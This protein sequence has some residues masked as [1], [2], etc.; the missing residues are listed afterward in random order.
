MTK[1]PPGG[2]VELVVNSVLAGTAT[3]DST[4][5]AT[6]ALTAEARGGKTE[7]DAYVF[8]EYCD[9]L[10]RVILIE[11]GMQGL[12]G[13]QCPRREVPGAFVVRQITTLVVN[14][15]ETAPSVLVRQGKAPAAWLTDEVDR[16][17]SRKAVNSPSRGLYGFGAGGIASLSGVRAVVVRR[18]RVRRRHQTGGV[19]RGRHVL[20]EA[21]LRDRS[22][23]AE[24]FATSG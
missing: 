5:T 2:T 7:A 23:L 20:A 15:S 6:F 19:L 4:G 16:P 11:P 14:V 9:T 24:A 18:R 1:A 3:A 22:V 8:V 12:P 17:P 21:V 10:R 13:G